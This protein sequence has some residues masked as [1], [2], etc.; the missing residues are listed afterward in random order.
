MRAPAITVIV[1]HYYSQDRTK[2]V[3]LGA[4]DRV[5][6]EKIVLH[7]LDALLRQGEVVFLRPDFTLGHFEDGTPVLEDEF[8]RRVEV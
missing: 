4:V 7:E 6:L 2:P 3:D 1:H 5:W 8:E